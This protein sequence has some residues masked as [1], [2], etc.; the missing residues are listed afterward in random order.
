MGVQ[1]TQLSAEIENNLPKTF[2]QKKIATHY[3]FAHESFGTNVT[4]NTINW[5]RTTI[6][7]FLY[8]KKL[9]FLL[10]F[11][12][13]L[14]SSI[15]IVLTQWVIFFCQ[16]MC[17]SSGNSGKLQWKCNCILTF[18]IW[19]IDF[20]LNRSNENG[21]FLTKNIPLYSCVLRLYF[22]I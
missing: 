15:H 18:I 4:K 10:F 20:F 12:L 6:I 2:Q 16:K 14:T 13:G 9:H 1:I 19:N 5:S 11:V 8:I 7:K 22:P 17:I 21:T 3:I